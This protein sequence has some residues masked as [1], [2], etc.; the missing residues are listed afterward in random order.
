MVGD[1]RGGRHPAMSLLRENRPARVV[2]NVSDDRAIDAMA[3][4]N[5]AAAANREPVGPAV[6]CVGVQDQR[7]AADH[8][9]SVD[10]FAG[11]NHDRTLRRIES[12]TII[13][14]ERRCDR[15]KVLL[16]KPDR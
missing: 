15:R 9:R 7:E 12:R 2:A 1:D 8:R 16:L 3:A 6:R 5:L 10:P 11:V 13:S 14:Q 4:P